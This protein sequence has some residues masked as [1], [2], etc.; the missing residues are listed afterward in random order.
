MS[1]FDIRR[2]GGAH[3]PGQVGSGRWDRV[4]ETA[5]GLLIDVLHIVLYA[6]HVSD[7][8]EAERRSIGVNVDAPVNMECQYD[9]VCEPQLWSKGN[10]RGERRLDPSLPL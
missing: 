6:R 3:T 1:V 8:I 9:A 5:V 10:L 2:D 7:Y 4:S